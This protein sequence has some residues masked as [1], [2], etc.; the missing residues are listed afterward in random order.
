MSFLS[1]IEAWFKAPVAQEV[2]SF[3]SGIVKSN[4]EAILPI[5]KQAVAGLV[6]AEAAQVASGNTSQT[7][8]TL[9]QA[10]SATEAA[11]I[12]AGVKASASEILTAVAAVKA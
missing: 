4:V 1:S 5:A 3:L 12:Q 2:E 10:V 8:H 11:V 7:G 6:V 9:A